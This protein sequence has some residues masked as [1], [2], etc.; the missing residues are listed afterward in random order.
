M[1]RPAP[2]RPDREATMPRLIFA[3]RNPGKVA[4]L[5]R[6][7][8]GQGIEV[9]DLSRHPEVEEIEE[10]GETFRDN[11]ILKA[12]VVAARTGTVA[13]ADDSGL[14]VD[15]LGGRPG[16]RS[17]RYAGEKASDDS[18]NAL[19][20]AEVTP[21]PSDARTARYRCAIAIAAPSGGCE[22]EEGSVE[23]VIVTEPRGSGGFGYDPF[24][25]VPGFGRTMA[26]LSAAE[27]DGISHRGIALR[28]ARPHL[29]RLLGVV[30]S[31]R[32]VDG[33]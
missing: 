20:V 3:T 30:A 27:K 29:L 7:L 4:E 18:N 1:L 31:E 13:L 32:T 19:L 24:F 33:E 11:A 15:G 22:V 5:E 12:T 23:G 17:A 25:W 21:L 2:V 28:R 9:E 6:M 26:E 8:A 10:T 16:V 14:E